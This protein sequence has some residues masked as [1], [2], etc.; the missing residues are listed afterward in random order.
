MTRRIGLEITRPTAKRLLDPRQP[1]VP[2]LSPK[3]QAAQ[4]PIAG[5]GTAPSRGVTPEGGG[6]GRAEPQRARRDTRRR[7]DPPVAA[8]RGQ[9]GV[10]SATGPANR[11]ARTPRFGEWPWKRLLWRA[12]KVGVLLGLSYVFLSLNAPLPE[13]LVGIY[14]TAAL[15]FAIDSQRTF[16]IALIFLVMV[17]VWSALGRAVQAENFAIYAFY[18]LVIGLIG[19][20]REL[21]GNRSSE[22][23]NISQESPQNP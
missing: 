19:A 10:P 15:L 5:A 18:F 14:A 22:T 20:M 21:S 2:A 8:Q 23:S 4:P 7:Q 1:L 16:L 13:Q 6:P 3:R 9:S 12:T 11:E 17:A